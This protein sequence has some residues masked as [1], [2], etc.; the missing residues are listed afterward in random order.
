[1]TDGNLAF[2]IAVAIFGTF[3]NCIVFRFT[4]I[5]VNDRTVFYSVI[6]W[7]SLAI[8]LYPFMPK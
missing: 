5:G 3:F 7:A 4:R 1:M 2:V 8:Y 6:G